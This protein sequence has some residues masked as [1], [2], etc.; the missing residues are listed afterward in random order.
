VKIA[1]ML[2]ESLDKEALAQPPKP[3]EFRVKPAW[4]RLFIMVGGV[5]M[6]FLLAFFIYSMIALA[7][8]EEY[9]PIK[10]VKMGY[11][12]NDATLKAGFQNGDIPL[13]ADNVPLKYMDAQTLLSIVGAKE[14][15]VLRNG[16][17]VTIHLPSDF[18][19]I[20][21][22]KESNFVERF[23]FVIKDVMGGSSALKAGLMAGDSVVGINGN[24]N[25]STYEIQNQLLENK[26][27]EITLNLYRNSQLLSLPITP[28]EAGKIGV[29]LKFPTEIYE[30]IRVHYNFF[31][32]I[33]AGV[34]IGVTTI[35]NYLGQFKYVFS[36]EGAKSLGGFGSIGNLFPSKWYWPAFWQ[37]TAF[38]SIILGVMN[39][40]P[41]PALDGGHVMFLLYEAVTGRKPNDKFMEYAQ[42]AGMIL[43]FGILIYANGND[44]L[45]WLKK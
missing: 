8:G 19:N 25:L 1:G 13:T 36:K 30:T 28:T 31:T 12:F 18:K 15:T 20:V 44:L 32:S 11:A 17:T 41:I 33:P 21:Y 5:L 22:S 34:R 37:M 26:E 43:L 42:I 39:L 24:M 10:N 45:R 7:W 14:V 3:W 35:K 40:L 23:P 16:E 29:A 9:L 6:N 2:D 4:Q 27:K 38:L